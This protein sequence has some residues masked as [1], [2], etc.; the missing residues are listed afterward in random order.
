MTDARP[1]EAIRGRLLWFEADPAGRADAHR[2]V[3]DGVILLRDGRIEAAGSAADFMPRLPARARIADHRPHLVLPGFIDPHIHFPQT[4]VI[5]SDAAD[6]MEW[7]SRYTFIEEQRF[8]DAGHAARN[9]RFFLDELIR[10]GTTTA[11]AWCSV[12]PHSVEAFFAEAERRGAR[13][14]AGKTMMDRNAP[15]ALTDTPARSYDESRALIA[16]WRGRGRLGYAVSPRFA[17]TSTAAQLEAAGALLREHPD[18]WMQTHMSENVREIE[19]VRSLFPEARDYLAVYERF[20]LIGP[21]TVWVVEEAVRQC[22]AWANDGH[23]LSVAVNVSQA[24]LADPAM[25]KAGRDAL[26]HVIVE[27]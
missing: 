11:L 19:T 27:H 16:R 22:R 12:H 8:A 5:A 17:V 25:S 3:E 18:C 1:L 21:L 6:L 24:N 10:N 26:Q 13:M 20:G 15:P 9:A 2:H 4:Q 23:Y 14:I 7:L